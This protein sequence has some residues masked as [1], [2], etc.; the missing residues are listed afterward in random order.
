MAVFDS[1]E[2]L[3]SFRNGDCGKICKLM[4]LTMALEPTLLNS[5]LTLDRKE[6][7]FQKYALGKRK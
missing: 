3:G 5:V 6:Q 4:V 2:P 1:G 7:I